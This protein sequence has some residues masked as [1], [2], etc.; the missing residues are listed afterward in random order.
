MNLV[1]ITLL[2]C[3]IAVPPDECFIGTAESIA[4]DYARSMDACSQIAEQSADLEAAVGPDA[5]EYIKMVCE[6]QLAPA[7]AAP[8]PEDPESAR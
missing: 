6:M 4:I 8:P 3:S 1:T 7:T 5:E 2:V